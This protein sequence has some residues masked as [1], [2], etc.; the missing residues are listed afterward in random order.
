MPSEELKG[1]WLRTSQYLEKFTREKVLIDLVGTDSP[2][3]LDIGANMGQSL[4]QFVH[5]WPNSKIYCFEPLMECHQRLNACKQSFSSTDIQIFDYAVGNTTN[6]SGI[7]FYTHDINTGLS[8]SDSSGLSGFNKMN[9]GSKDSINIQKLKENAFEFDS[10]I[11]NINK[12]RKVPCIRLDD[13]IRE[14]GLSAINLLKI[15]TQGYEPEVLEGAGQYLSKVQVV[16]SELMLYDLYS[17][18][19]SFSDIEKFLIPAGF[20]LFDISHISKNP[21]N[22]R[23]D[24]VDVIY[25][26]RNFH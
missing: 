1:N 12:D 11:S 21:M 15:D 13:W 3:I 17:R 18:S 16:I 7:E 6:S 22:G 20:S 10:Y 19:L 26:N 14:N 9:T 24:W 23:T 2:V 5:I 4:E 8:G 25:V